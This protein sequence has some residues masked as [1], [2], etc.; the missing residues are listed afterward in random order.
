MTN[1][2]NSQRIAGTAAGLIVGMWNE[3]ADLWN[4]ERID[5]EDANIDLT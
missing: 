5:P 3:Y 4:L 2:F 1:L